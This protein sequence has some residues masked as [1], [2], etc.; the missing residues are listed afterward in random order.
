MSYS[1]LSWGEGL[2]PLQSRSRFILQPQATGQKNKKGKLKSKKR[3]IEERVIKLEQEIVIFF[4][5]FYF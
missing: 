1:G 4:D 5:F 2:T 3:S